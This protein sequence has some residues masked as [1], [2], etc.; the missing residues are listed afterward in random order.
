MRSLPRAR[1]DISELLLDALEGPPHE[2]PRSELPPT[3]EPLEDD[4]LHLALYLSYELH[5]RGLP[6]VDEGWEWE[7]SLLGRRRGLEDLFERALL[8]AVPRGTDPVPADGMDLAL[9]AVAEDD[10]PSLSAYINVSASLDEVRE[11]V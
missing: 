5:Y 9:R 8:E 4:D 1:G 2:L 6:G 3:R 11:F 10:G 7:P